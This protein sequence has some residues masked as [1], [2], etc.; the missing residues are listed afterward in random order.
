MKKLMIAALAA[1]T[2][3]SALGAEQ[4]EIDTRHAHAFVQ[5][6]ISHMGFSWL[7]G[8]FN[9]FEGQ[10]VLD[11]EN[12][13]NSSASAV[14]ETASVDTNHPARDDHL[15]SDDFLDVSNHPQARFQSTSFETRD[16]GSYLLTGDFTL[17]GV[18]RAVEIEVEEVGAGEDPWGGFR[19]GFA[20]TT[21]L[22]LAD[23]GIDFDLGPAAT[24]VEI[25]LSMEGVRREASEDEA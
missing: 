16:D 1:L 20:G 25:T 7:Y 14:I 18:T 12:P 6:R 21:T 22:K 9:D 10:F 23:Y 13:E 2:S 11:P 3:L 24:E 4:Y 5:F 19:R 15:R 17:R 8:R